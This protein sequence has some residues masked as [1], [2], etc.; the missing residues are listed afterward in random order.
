MWCGRSPRWVR[1]HR[2]DRTYKRLRP[3]ARY[4]RKLLG[5]LCACVWTCVRNEVRRRLGRDDVTPGMVA[6]IQTYGGLLHWHPHFHTLVTCGAFTAE[7]EFLDVPE[8]DME[9]LEAAWREA[10]FALYLAEEKV[11]PEVVENMRSWPCSGFRVDQSVYLPAGDTAGIE[12]LVGYLQGREGR[13][14]AVSGGRRRRL[15]IGAVAPVS[16]V[17]WTGPCGG[18]DVENPPAH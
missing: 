3:H 2:A 11:T 6:A 14:P 13:L 16:P 7:S 15:A 5:K 17:R 8:L 12:R 10:V 4:D 1:S 18:V 9:R